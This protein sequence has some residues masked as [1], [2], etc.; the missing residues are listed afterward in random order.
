M[1]VISGSTPAY[2]DGV[3]E[4]PRGERGGADRVMDAGPTTTP[5][6]PAAHPLSAAR[7][8]VCLISSSFYGWGH[9]SGPGRVTRMLGRELARRGARV[10]AIVPRRHGQREVEQVDGITVLGYPAGSPW[11]ALRLSRECDADIYHSQGPTLATLL[12]AAARPRR[13]HVIT[14]RDAPSLRELGRSVRA[15]IPDRAR[16]VLPVLRD[17]HPLRWLGAVPANA[18]YCSAEELVALARARLHRR[19]AGF[20]PAPVSVPRRVQK[21]RVPTVCFLG[22][23][24]PHRHPERVLALAARFPSVRIIAI[25]RSPDRAHDLELRRAFARYA[26]LHAPGAVNQFRSDALSQTLSE[27]WV[28]VSTGGGRGLPDACVEGAA[29]G[30][31]ILSDADPDAFATRFGHHAATGDLAAGLEALLAGDAWRELGARGH[32]HVLATFD[33][34]VALRRHLDAYGEVLA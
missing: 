27:S 12:A 26:N 32:A 1:S 10:T 14:L 24:A 34:E 17:E 6:A 3:A 9:Y 16:D 33:A 11:H 25:G 18:V 8:R 23:W 13:R 20:L 31:A 2:R 28:L 29:H 15:L 4:A 21:S 19:T 30:C 22:S 5:A 7:L